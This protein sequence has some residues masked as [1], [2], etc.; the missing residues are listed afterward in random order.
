MP[1]LSN[2]IYGLKANTELAKRRT[3]RNGETAPKFKWHSV[4]LCV[5][6][7]PCHLKACKSNNKFQ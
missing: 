6:F 7:A 3:P 1:G 5:C 2:V 4:L